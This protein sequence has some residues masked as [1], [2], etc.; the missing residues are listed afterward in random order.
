MRDPEME[1][2]YQQWITD[3]RPGDKT[4]RS[5]MRLLV[6]GRAPIVRITPE[7]ACRS[8]ARY[9]AHAKQREFFGM[10]EPQIVSPQLYAA[11]EREV[12]THGRAAKRRAFEKAELEASM[13]RHIGPAQ[14][15]NRAE[16]RRMAARKRRAK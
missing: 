7:E 14:A 3:G 11:I 12:Q 16:R 4:P 5:L 2:A 8:F 15:P 9:R 13:C 1:R 10:P 6:H